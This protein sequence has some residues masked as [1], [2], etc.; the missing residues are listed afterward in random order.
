[1][2]MNI[3]TA[4]VLLYE[5]PEPMTAD[6][7]KRLYKSELESISDT[8]GYVSYG[9]Q[10]IKHFDVFVS[11]NI[12]IT[13]LPHNTL[14]IYT[15]LSYPANKMLDWGEAVIAQSQLQKLGDKLV[16]NVSY[17]ILSDLL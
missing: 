10:F 7:F 4:I 6:D 5:P 12:W 9:K 8:I 14:C 16:G 3:R 15:W 1:M 13:D 17:K 11:S 2:S